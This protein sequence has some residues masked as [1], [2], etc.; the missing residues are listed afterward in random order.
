MREGRRTGETDGG[1]EGRRGGRGRRM[2]GRTE[3]SI[4]ITLQC[5]PKTASPSE[6][7]YP[8]VVAGGRV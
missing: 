1:R 3:G 4:R 6:A 7:V 5:L 8:K 2:N